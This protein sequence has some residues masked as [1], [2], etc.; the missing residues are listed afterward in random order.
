M[1]EESLISNEELYE[2]KLKETFSEEAEEDKES[3]LDIQ[4][5]LDRNLDIKRYDRMIQDVISGINAGRIILNPDYQ[6]NYVWDNKKASKLVE[7]LLLSIPI[8]I[9][10]AAEEE[11]GEWNVVDGLQ[12][13]YSLKRFYDDSFSLTGLEVLSE[14]NGK[15][16]SQLSEKIVKRIDRGDLS[17]VLL[18]STTDP[19]IQYD[20]FIRLNSGA[21]HLNEQELRNCL[22]RG[23]LNDYVK[24]QLVNNEEF[25]KIF[26]LN[27]LKK[28]MIDVEIILRYLA[29][30]EYFDREKGTITGYDGRVKNLINR[31]MI[32][33][34]NTNERK[35]LNLK[36][37]FDVNI[38]K[39]WEIFDEKAFK[40]IN[41][42]GTYD[43]RI[44]RP[45]YETIMISFESYELE[46][47]KKNK[48]R[49]IDETEN[50]I[51]ENKDFNDYISTATGNTTRTEGRIKIYREMLENI[52]DEKNS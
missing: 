49:I 6:R 15:K 10:Y 37:K 19:N 18:L 17:I 48:K 11:T 30:S 3:Q 8:P 2:E 22:Y 36:Q 27:V 42:N 13:L 25:I 52:F 38:A 28:R 39:C 34:Q 26:N 33:F 40:K 20:I 7:S 14:L 44:N 32:E 9:I 29:F 35:L 5:K 16:Y 43:T 51:K 1:K 4:E 23:A 45:L 12:R 21:V 24:N 47:L 46:L 31:F 50:L 41:L